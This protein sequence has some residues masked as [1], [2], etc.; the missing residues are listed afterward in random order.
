I[1]IAQLNVV[2]RLNLILLSH[3]LII[4]Q[5][6]YYK[7]AALRFATVLTPSSAAFFARVTGSHRHPPEGFSDANLRDVDRILYNVFPDLLHADWSDHSAGRFH[8]ETQDCIPACSADQAIAALDH[9]QKRTSTVLR[10]PHVANAEV[11]HTH[12]SSGS[13]AP[14]LTDSRNVCF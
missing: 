5:F 6:P 10:Y 11:H 8:Y 13:K 1:S 12:S 2:V 7:N 14:D 3:H 4:P 9:L